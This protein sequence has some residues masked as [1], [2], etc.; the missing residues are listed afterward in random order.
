MDIPPRYN[1]SS[2]VKIVCKLQRALYE[3]K[4]SPQAWFGRFSSTM[5]KYDFQRSN[6]DH[7]LFLKH[8]LRK[9][10][11]LIVYV[12]DITITVDD[13]EEISRLQDQIN[14]I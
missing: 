6:S 14:Q 3:L 7:T 4:Q 1:A 2:E 10:I 5:R 9:E 12:D 13:A 8:L 11:T